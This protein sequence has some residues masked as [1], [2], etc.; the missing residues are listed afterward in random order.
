MAISAA[1]GVG[2]KIVGKAISAAKKKKKD[3]ETKG[4]KNKKNC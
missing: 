2:K 3:L 1:I 4:K